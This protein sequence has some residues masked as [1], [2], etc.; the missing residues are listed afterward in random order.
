MSIYII[1]D[2]H[3]CY[4]ELT[5]LFDKIRF[6][7]KK[8]K[9]IFVGDL[10]NRGPDS[11]KVLRFVR[12]LGDSAQMTL[13]NHDIS[14]LAYAAGVYHGRGTDFPTIM[15]ARDSENLIDWLRQQPVLIKDTELNTIVVHAGIP[16]RWSLAKAE[17]QAAKTEKKLRGKRFKDYLAYTYGNAADQWQKDFDKYAKF[18]YR[19][20][21]FSRMRYCD[22]KGEPDF[23]DKCP[24]GKQPPN[25]SPWFESRKKQQRDDN[26]RL[27]FGHWAA[28]G[29]YQS[30][31]VMCLD[32]GCA[33]GGALTAVKVEKDSIKTFQV[34]A[35]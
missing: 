3:G 29:Y 23:K 18:S 30:D 2:V 19:I 7:P 14:L 12:E 25:L 33:W 8:D 13:G 1:G 32:S 31:N 15:R 20:N 24:L 11:L 22:E 9:V 34:A 27:F 35:Q 26:T 17:K 4:D 16:P 28:L 6:R 21:G 5:A 10:V